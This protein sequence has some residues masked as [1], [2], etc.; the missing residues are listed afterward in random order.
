[1]N[2]ERFEADPDF[3]FYTASDPEPIFYIV[4]PDLDS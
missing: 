3:T 1:M 4:D 2:P